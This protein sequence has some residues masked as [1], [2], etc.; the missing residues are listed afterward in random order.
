MTSKGPAS[1]KKPRKAPGKSEDRTS[2]ELF[3]V[4]SKD[5][6][7]LHARML[8]SAKR[9]Y[10]SATDAAHARNL[11]RCLFALAEGTAFGLK[12][13]AMGELLD[14]GTFGPPGAKELV[15]EERYDLNKR[16]EI[17]TRPLRV[18][19]EQNV[20]FAFRFYCE[21]YD[22]SNPLD[23]NSDWWHALKR[24]QVVRDRLMHPRQPED[25]DITPKEVMD[26][27]VAKHGFIECVGK[28]VL[29]KE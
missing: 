2:G 29:R 15:F 17:I 20:K 3:L 27:V 8:T 24:A 22:I 26:A 23:T 1:R 4:L 5:F 9:G 25:L 28:I 13:D 21:T 11:N 6:D 10:V 12:V 14:R 16:G 7:R 19:V 18:P